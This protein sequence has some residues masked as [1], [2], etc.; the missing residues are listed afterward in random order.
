MKLLIM[1]RP[2]YESGLPVVVREQFK[3][4]S[5]TTT[6]VLLLFTQVFRTFFSYCLLQRL[7]APTQERHFFSSF[8][9]LVSQRQRVAP[10]ERQPD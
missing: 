2:N 9:T 8:Q 4:P 3:I 1:F 6:E 5:G 10:K 7:F